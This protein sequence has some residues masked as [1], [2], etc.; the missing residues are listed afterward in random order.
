MERHNAHLSSFAEMLENHI[1][2]V[3][4]VLRSTREAQGKWERGRRGLGMRSEGMRERILRLKLSGWER[5]VFDGERVR[6][7]CE[8]ALGEL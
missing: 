3:E 5:R 2:D 4:G 6:D 1:D 7:V 8:R